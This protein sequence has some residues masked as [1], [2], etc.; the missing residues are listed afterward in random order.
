MK[1]NEHVKST[2]RHLGRPGTNARRR[3]EACA[4]VD[5]AL[6]QERTEKAAKPTEADEKK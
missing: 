6:E 4:E 5:Q 2:D 1:E 3:K